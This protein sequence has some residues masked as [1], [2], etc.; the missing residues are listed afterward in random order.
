MKKKKKI[1]TETQMN[2]ISADEDV[3]RV[4]NI[5]YDYNLTFAYLSGNHDSFSKTLQTDFGTF[6]RVLHIFLFVAFDFGLLKYILFTSKSIKH[7]T[8]GS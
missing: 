4:E 8:S 2:D 7:K 6:R 1:R 3:T 5:R